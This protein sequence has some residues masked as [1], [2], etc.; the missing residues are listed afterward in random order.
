MSPITEDFNQYINSHWP[1]LMKEPGNLGLK[2]EAYYRVYSLYMNIIKKEQPFILI[3]SGIKNNKEIV[4]NFGVV[5][6]SFLIKKSKIKVEIKPFSGAILAEN[7]W[8]VLIN[9]IFML[10]AI[11]RCCDVQLVSPNG[12]MPTTIEL[13]DEKKKCFKPL[14]RELAILLA[15]R[16]FRQNSPTHLGVIFSHQVE[17]SQNQPLLTLTQLRDNI[18]HISLA[19]VQAFLKIKQRP[20]TPN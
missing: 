13:W 20:I 14:G 1:K 9:D 10:A 17:Q 6:S 7:P 16:Y 4:D 15:C 19:E 3:G 5:T 2:K 18:S 8:S 11:H 12:D